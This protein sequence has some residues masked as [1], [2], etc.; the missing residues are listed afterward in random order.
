MNR[1][2]YARSDL[3]REG[4]KL[5]IRQAVD[6]LDDPTTQAIVEETGIYCTIVSEIARDLVAAGELEI[7]RTT[8]TG[9]HYYGLAETHGPLNAQETTA[10]R[11]IE[12]ASQSS[13]RTPTLATDGGQP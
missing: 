11:L 3:E 4:K 13:D 8:P 12:R 7:V 1:Q 6:Q 10:R 9:A 5:A 2:A